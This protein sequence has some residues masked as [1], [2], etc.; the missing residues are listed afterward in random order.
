MLP[1]KNR[2]DKKGINLIFKKGNFITSSS[3]IFKFILINDSIRPHISFIAPKNIAKLAIKRNLLRR[4]GY[5]ILKK[6][7]DQ[8]P[9]RILGVFIFKKPE[10]DISKI[11][12]EIKDILNKIN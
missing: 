11:E 12:Y 2:V 7:I 9:S 4:K 10:E 1:K 3:F 8:F 6:Y 5:Y